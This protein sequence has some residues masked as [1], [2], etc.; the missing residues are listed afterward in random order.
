MTNKEGG[1]QARSTGCGES[2]DIVG[3]QTRFLK[4]LLNE[5]SQDEGVIARSD[6]W[7]D[8]AIG[9]MQVDLRRDQRRQDLCFG[10]CPITQDRYRAF[11]AGCF[12]PQ[13]DGV[14]LD[15]RFHIF[16][17][18]QVIRVLSRKDPRHPGSFRIRAFFKDLLFEFTEIQLRGGGKIARGD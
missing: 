11:I 7:N 16:D 3:L 5:R 14:A 8:S 2:I 12:D 18:W 17:G 6:F 10:A 13:E 9:T 15:L 1:G 4:G